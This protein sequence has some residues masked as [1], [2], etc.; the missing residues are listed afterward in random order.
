MDGRNALSDYDLVSLRLFLSSVDGCSIAAAAR[1][2]NIATSAVSK[3]ISDLEA[4]ARVV[5]LHRGRDGVVP[6]AAGQAFYRQA[7]LVFDVLGRLDAEISDYVEG[8]QGVVRIHANASAITQFLPDDIAAFNRLYPD[9]RFDL[10]EET[11]GRS[12]TAV[13]NG[14]A[15]LAIFSEHAA[16]DG[17]ETRLYRRDSLM[18]V[19]ARDHP[20]SSQT[21]LRLADIL[22]YDHVGLQEGSSL[23]ARIRAAAGLLGTEVRTRV[24]V[25]SFEG[26]RRM[27]EVGLG[28]AVLPQGV[29]LPYLDSAQIAAVALDEAWATRSLLVGYRDASSLTQTCRRLIDVLAPP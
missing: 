14:D 2:N 22:A 7:R 10:R 11:S 12:I 16:H 6:T 25:L 8:A 4:R 28:V 24:N 29:V 13:A 23:Q 18:V 27:V 5:L 21:A 3:R 9:V 19:M 17:L 15:D 20:L 1:A 26:V